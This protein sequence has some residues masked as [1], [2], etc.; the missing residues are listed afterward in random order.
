MNQKKLVM[1]VTALA[2]AGGILAGCLSGCG[3]RET[4]T[5]NKGT[6]ETKY[7]ESYPINT[8]EKLA[9]ATWTT[10]HSDYLNYREQPFY[11]ALMEQTG[12]D[13]DFKFDIVGE[14]FNM[15]LAS[16]ELPDIIQC[17][18]YNYPGGPQQALD[19]G[20]II[21]LT[22]YINKWAPNLRKYLDAHPD[23]DKDIKTDDGKYY[24]FPFIRGDES[25]VVF[26]GAM[27]RK[28]LLDA[29]GLEAPETIEEWEHVLTVFKENGVKTPLAIST[30]DSAKPFFS[31]YNVTNEFYL[32]NGEVKYGPLEDGYKQFIELFNK[33]YATGLL[34]PDYGTLTRQ[35]VTGKI[36]SGM[37]GAS[38]GTA[39]SLMGVC[40]AAG[41]GE[42]ENFELIGTK[43]PVLNKGD[44]PEFGTWE[45]IYSSNSTT[46]IT[47]SC[48]NIELAVR[49]L[50]YAYGEEGHM[51]YNFGIEG[52]SYVMEDGYPKYTDEMYQYEGGDITASLKRYIM[53][54]DHAPCIQDP[55]MYEQSLSYQEQKDA[56]DVWGKTNMKDHIIPHIT[57][58]S[59]ESEVIANL[60]TEI[61]T[62]VNENEKLFILGKKPLSEYDS[63][64]EKIKQMGIDQVIKVKQDAYDRYVKR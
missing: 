29:F 32:D 48:E 43:Y 39:R 1:R 44:Y 56:I 8:D 40:L 31:A 3:T 33:W 60:Y 16:G 42:N 20:I 64:V 38:V 59:E 28:D 46:A 21:D 45:M 49:V 17:D 34:D 61:K 37:V 25:L 51:L 53:S 7:T 5:N 63:F 22:E 62:Y 14:T 19:D 50:D 9:W 23:V 36:S 55:R 10:S 54:I 24:A 58:T 11:K 26:E 35:M 2:M 41:K 13:I 15:M 4:T 27:I 57:Y 52:E 6:E 30:A 18:W 47:T 12:V